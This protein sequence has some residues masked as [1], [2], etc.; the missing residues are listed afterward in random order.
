VKEKIDL[1]SDVS[2]LLAQLRRLAASRLGRKLQLGELIFVEPRLAQTI[3]D[4]DN[5]VEV[6]GDDELRE[7]WLALRRRIVRKA[8]LVGLR[9]LSESSKLFIAGA[10]AEESGK[11]WASL[12][13]PEE[14]A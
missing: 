3:V 8:A 4:I 5:A 7:E 10:E 11:R 1:S 14:L 2:I 12:A 9:K 13:E 6:W